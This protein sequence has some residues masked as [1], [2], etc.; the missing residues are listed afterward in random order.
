MTDPLLDD[1]MFEEPWFFDPW[2]DAELTDHPITDG[3]ERML[4]HSIGILRSAAQKAVDHPE[5]PD[6]NGARPFLPGLAPRVARFIAGFLAGG[7]PSVAVLRVIARTMAALRPLLDRDPLPD[8]PR[9]VPEPTSEGTDSIERLRNERAARARER[10]AA[11]EEA[12]GRARPGIPPTVRVPADI[13]AA[14]RENEP[15][16][17]LLDLV[18]EALEVYIA[19]RH[20]DGVAAS[21]ELVDLIAD[22][23]DIDSPESRPK[24]GQPAA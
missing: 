8:G 18:S 11:R 19:F 6:P 2:L 3:G 17:D 4:N 16:N 21:L 13:V 5:P 10:G 1:S 20:G 9:P 7:T 23:L 15:W 24:E 12:S 14:R 22:V